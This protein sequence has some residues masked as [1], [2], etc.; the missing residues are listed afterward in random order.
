MG[1]WWVLG[2]WPPGRTAAC[3]VR[4]RAGTAAA[5]LQLAQCTR[6]LEMYSTIYRGKHQRAHIPCV[7]PPGRCPY[8]AG[9]LCSALSGACAAYQWIVHRHPHH[10]GLLFWRGRAGQVA[11]NGRSR[12]F[13]TVHFDGFLVQLAHPQAT[14]RVPSC[15]A[16]ACVYHGALIAGPLHGAHPRVP[17]SLGP[18]LVSSSQHCPRRSQL[19]TISTAGDA[20]LH[21]CSL[22][23]HDTD[24]G[25]LIRPR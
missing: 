21:M 4:S 6:N 1:Q 9:V 20:A 13:L 8:P 24:I 11:A 5:D 16:A 22:D 14:P 12:D 2:P 17:N 15:T 19:A 23:T 10:A 18:A 7:L 25:I 3:S